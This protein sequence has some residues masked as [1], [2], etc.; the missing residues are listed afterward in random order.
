[1]LFK[2]ARHMLVYGIGAS[3]TDCNPIMLSEPQMVPVA[4][5]AACR[6]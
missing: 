5:K 1:M 6:A 2:T 3:N 4:S